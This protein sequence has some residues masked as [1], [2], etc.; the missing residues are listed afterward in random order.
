MW[1]IVRVVFW[2][3]ALAGA[4]PVLAIDEPMITISGHN[5]GPER[6]EVHVG[7]TVRWRAAG[8]GPVQLRLDA[9]PSAHPVILREGEVRAVFLQPG[10]HRYSGSV[11][12]DGQRW[13][14]GVVVV[15]PSSEPI[16]GPRICGPSSSQLICIEP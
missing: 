9:H 11:V 13:F 15:R 8:G 1:R 7:E 2:A 6:I 12:R 5:L 16:D 14:R 3:A 4:T 10:E